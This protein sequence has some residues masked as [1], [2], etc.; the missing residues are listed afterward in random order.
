[1]G[2]LCTAASGPTSH[3]PS[4]QRFT[5]GHSVCRADGQRSGF[6]FTHDSIFVGE[7]GPTH[8][9]VEQ[10][11]ALRAI[12]N[13]AVWRPGDA[14]ETVAAWN[15]ALRRDT[16]PTALVLSRQNLPVLEQDG[17]EA[18]AAR[19]GWLAL[20][21]SA[22]T[23]E[24]AIAATGSEL[25]AAPDAARA[26]SLRRAGACGWFRY[27]ASSRRARRRVPGVGAAGERAVA[28]RRGAGRG[29]RRAAR[30]RDER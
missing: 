15:A 23:A 21:E 29:R 24:L 16:G 13:L 8:Q 22:G 11:A 4:V 19:G 6:I 7:D 26:R 5:R 28:H 27:R 17:V 12:P 3:L 9:P 14:R 18:G 1:M 25:H 20:R 2:S 10:L 30:P